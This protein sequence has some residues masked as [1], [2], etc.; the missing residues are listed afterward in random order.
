MVNGKLTSILIWVSNLFFSPKKILVGGFLLVSI[1]IISTVIIIN[2]QNRRQGILEHSRHVKEEQ[3]ISSLK[4]GDVI[5]RLGD[6]FWSGFFKKLSPTEKR[7]SHLGIVR[8]RENNISVIHAEGLTDEDNVK[9]VSLSDFLKIALSIGVF[10][11]QNIEGANISDIAF[12]YKGRPFDWSFDMAE[13][14]RL[15]CTELLY[16]ILQRLDPTIELNT[17]WIKEMGK[18]IL[19]VDIVSQSEHFVEIGSWKGLP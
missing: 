19:P 1:V 7:F 10:R 18:F 11:A 3:I 2:Q 13:A 12:E 17:V 9:E 8:I 6:K 15:Y 5:C 14:D 16:V 4:D